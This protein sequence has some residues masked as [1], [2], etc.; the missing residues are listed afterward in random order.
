MAERLA[1]MPASQAR[2]A[3]QAHVERY[4]A[5]RKNAPG[6]SGRLKCAGDR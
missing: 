4:R 2:A 1:A 3:F 6:D 5:C